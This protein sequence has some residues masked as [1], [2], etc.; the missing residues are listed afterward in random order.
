MDQLSKQCNVAILKTG[1]C[2]SAKSLV[3]KKASVSLSE[4]QLKKLLG[5]MFTCHMQVNMSHQLQ[6][7]KYHSVIFL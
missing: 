5:Y 1:L 3:K 7:S 4:I 6:Q 2:R